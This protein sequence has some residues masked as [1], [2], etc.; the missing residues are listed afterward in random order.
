MKN[1]QIALVMIALIVVVAVIG[2]TTRQAV[3]ALA[4]VG[5][6]VVIGALG[7]VRGYR[8]RNR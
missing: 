5:A 8:R 7:I 2:L 1:Y 4:L 6:I 3:I